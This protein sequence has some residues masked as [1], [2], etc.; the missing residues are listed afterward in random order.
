MKFKHHNWLFGFFILLLL[1]P[2]WVSAYFSENSRQGSAAI[3][4]EMHPESTTR[5]PGTLLG[6]E[7][8][9]LEFCVRTGIIYSDPY[10][11]FKKLVLNI[12]HHRY[13]PAFKG[14][15]WLMKAFG[16]LK[17]PCAG[18]DFGIEDAYEMYSNDKELGLKRGLGFGFS[19]PTKD[20]FNRLSRIDTPDKLFANVIVSGKAYINGNP[21]VT[22]GRQSIVDAEIASPLVLDVAHEAAHQIL[23]KP[24][25]ISQG[26]YHSKDL[27]SIMWWQENDATTF[28]REEKALILDGL[29]Q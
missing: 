18:A 28:T 13:E 5:K 22:I 19:Q 11:L 14:N 3:S 7:L 29:N 4:A 17:D 26:T 15:Q 25:F 23:D 6:F 27:N 21:G 8:R 1:I 10:G 24:S 2:S 12:I 9:L 16:F 20:V